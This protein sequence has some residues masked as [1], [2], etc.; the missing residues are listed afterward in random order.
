MLK[1]L[2]DSMVRFSVEDNGIGLSEAQSAAQGPQA[3]LGMSLIKAFARQ[4]DGKLTI[5]G[6]PG[7]IVTIEFVNKYQ[8]FAAAWRRRA[9]LR[10]GGLGPG[11]MTG[12]SASRRVRQTGSAAPAAPRR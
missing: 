12:L 9:E 5:S 10:L 2:G 1:T 6:P 11:F 8:P 3:S 4:V 7:T